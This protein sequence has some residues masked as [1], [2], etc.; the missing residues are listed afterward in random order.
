MFFQFGALEYVFSQNFDFVF[1]KTVIFGHTS[2]CNLLKSLK[3]GA[4]LEPCG[5]A[6]CSFEA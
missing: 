5:H 1:P 3:S 6:L 4:K 2:A